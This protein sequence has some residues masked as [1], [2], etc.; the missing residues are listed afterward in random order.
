M[1]LSMVNNG[2]IKII[3]I[4]GGRQ[5]RIK[6]ASLGINEGM[7]IVVKRRGIMGGPILVNVNGRDIAIGRGLADK[8]IVVGVE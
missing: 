6:L 2:K 4:K 5:V 3:N 8:L 1:T 7:V